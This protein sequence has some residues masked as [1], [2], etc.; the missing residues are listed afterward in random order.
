MV[1]ITLALTVTSLVSPEYTAPGLVVAYGGAY[2]VGAALSYQLL[3]RSLGGLRTPVL[4]RFLVRMLIASGVAGAAAWGWR[5]LLDAVWDTGDGKGQALVQLAT[6]GLVDVVVLL[7]CARAMRIT[8]VTEVL[9]AL[10]GRLR[11]RRPAG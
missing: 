7:L 6:T 2:A 9:G 5:L 8:E 10:T 1:N 4:V 11:R 3:R